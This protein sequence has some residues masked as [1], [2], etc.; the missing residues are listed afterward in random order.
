MPVPTRRPRSL[1]PLT[2]LRTAFSPVNVRRA[3]AKVAASQ[4]IKLLGRSDNQSLIRFTKVAEKDSGRKRGVGGKE[5]ILFA[6]HTAA[7]D[8]KNRHGL[9][10][11]LGFS[12]E[13][14]S[15]VFGAHRSSAAP[16]EA[17]E[18]PA[19]AEKPAEPEQAT[20]TLIDRIFD[21]FHGDMAHVVDFLVA[22]GQLHYGADDG[23]IQLEKLD[24][25]YGERMLADPKRFLAAVHHWVKE[26][27]AAK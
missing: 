21:T 24:P 15:P 2:L 4:L 16:T 5:R 25:A 12:V 11:K 20:P 8:A 9:P 19:P 27:E 22:R 23:G 10:D 1:A 26:Q 3:T 7:C 17:K 13:A 18:A 14:L 6:T